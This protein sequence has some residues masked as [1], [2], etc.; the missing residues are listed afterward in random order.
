VQA[1]ISTVDGKP[2][3][4]KAPRTIKSNHMKGATNSSN[5]TNLGQQPGI[6]A[7]SLEQI[8]TLKK[9]RST[10]PPTAVR[11]VH[12]HNKKGKCTKISF[13]HIEK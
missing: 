1:A 10:L 9:H 4:T 12:E 8:A 2:K 5:T 13:S 6:T 3:P 7:D 11:K